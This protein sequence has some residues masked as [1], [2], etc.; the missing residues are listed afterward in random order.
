[1]VPAPE[2]KV[3]TIDFIKLLANLKRRRTVKHNDDEGNFFIVPA[4]PK[5]QADDRSKSIRHKR[6]RYLR[7]NPKDSFVKNRQLLA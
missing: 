5:T 7:I 6:I 4:P 1:M 2:V 3:N